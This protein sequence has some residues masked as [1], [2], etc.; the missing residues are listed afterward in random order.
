[1]KKTLKLNLENLKKLTD[2]EV[3]GPVGGA[4]LSAACKAA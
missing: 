2:A 3:R 4:M 1:M